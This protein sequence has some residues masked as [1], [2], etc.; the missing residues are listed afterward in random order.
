MSKGER[1][2]ELE[3]AQVSQMENE[4]ILSEQNVLVELFKEKQDYLRRS[5]KWTEKN[6][7]KEMLILLFFEA[8]RQLESRWNCNTQLNCLIKLKGEKSWLRRIEKKK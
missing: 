7:K 4:R 5:L 1:N 6:G 8:G 2:R 3:S